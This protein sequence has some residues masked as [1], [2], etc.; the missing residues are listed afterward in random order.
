[1]VTFIL[2]KNPLA[3][4]FDILA[5]IEDLF[6]ICKFIRSFNIPKWCNILAS[7]HILCVFGLQIVPKREKC[8][9]FVIYHLRKIISYFREGQY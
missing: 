2:L 1:M 4:F 3:H 5:K 8:V 6:A 7:N 9:R